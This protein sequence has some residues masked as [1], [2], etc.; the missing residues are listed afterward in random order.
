MD[1]PGKSNL[2]LIGEVIYFAFVGLWIGALTDRS[3]FWPH[4]KGWQPK[5][6]P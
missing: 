3:P 2:T 1:H 5:G 4:E 6:H